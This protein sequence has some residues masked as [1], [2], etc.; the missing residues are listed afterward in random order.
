MEQIFL[1]FGMN[2]LF[3]GGPAEKFLDKLIEADLKI[4]WTCAIRAD[5]MGKDE[6][7]KGNPIPREED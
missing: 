1:T 2:Y 5:L 7:S 4:H 3:I 6:D